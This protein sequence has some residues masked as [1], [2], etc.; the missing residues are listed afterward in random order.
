[1]DARLIRATSLQQAI[2][3]HNAEIEVA[4][5]KR[6]QYIDALS[7]LGLTPDTVG[8]YLDE[9]RARRDMLGQSLDQQMNEI[10]SKLRSIP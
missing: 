2:Q 3:R 9:L 5:V 8:P 4:R 7:L 1:M 10:E 6:Q